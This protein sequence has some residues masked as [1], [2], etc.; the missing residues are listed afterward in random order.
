MRRRAALLAS[1]LVCVACGSRAVVDGKLLAQ[2][3]AT[4]AACEVELHDE[5]GDPGTGL[6]CHESEASGNDPGSS[7]VRIGRTFECVTVGRDGSVDVTATC[8]GYEP[9]R[10]APLG[11]RAVHLGEIVLQRSAR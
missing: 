3:G 11:P 10:S 8:A 1:A 6:Q 5:V 2:D 4:D 9:Y 7:V